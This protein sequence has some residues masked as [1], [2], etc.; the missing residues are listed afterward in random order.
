MTSYFV[1]EAPGGADRDHRSTRFIADRFSWLALLFPWAW[2]AIHRLWWLSIAIIV[3]QVAA[4][5][6]SGLG[7]FGII[8]SLF[9]LSVGLIAGLEGRNIVARHLVLKGWT[10]KAVI[11]ARD[12]STAEE[13]YFS[14]LAEDD[15]AE[16]SAIPQPEWKRDRTNGNGFMNDPA[17][18][19]QFDLNGRR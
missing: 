15:A 12:L 11:P 19:F 1:L 3:L 4:S 2:F 13:T 7:G 9:A 8:G 16:V 18:S 6:M 10:L 14:N 17:G 5:Q